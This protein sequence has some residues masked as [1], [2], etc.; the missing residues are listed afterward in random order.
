MPDVKGVACYPKFLTVVSLS[1]RDPGHARQ[2]AVIA[3][4]CGT[5]AYMGRYVVVVDDDF[6]PFDMNDVMWALYTRTDPSKDIDLIRRCWSGPLDPI[7][8]HE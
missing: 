6:D 7:I 5:G 1:Q 2:A 4:Q 3:A 8:R